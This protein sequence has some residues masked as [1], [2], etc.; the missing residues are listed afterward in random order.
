M[1]AD[2]V[3]SKNSIIQ[4]DSEEQKHFLSVNTEQTANMLIW[5]EVM[6]V[7]Y[8]ACVC[9][10]EAQV[11]VYM[12]IFTSNIFEDGSNLAFLLMCTSLVGKY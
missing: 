5:T 8:N 9:V 2:N 11:W 12:T 4:E 3:F 6:S 10:D 7:F 1:A